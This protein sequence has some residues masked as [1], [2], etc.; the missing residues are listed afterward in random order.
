MSLVMKDINGMKMKKENNNVLM[1]KDIC[2]YLSCNMD[3]RVTIDE[4]ALMFHISAT[5]LK[6]AFKEVSG[7]S[8]YA[9]QRQQKMRAAADDLCRTD[10]TVLQIAGRYGYENGSKFAKAFRD[11]MGMSPSRYRKMSRGTA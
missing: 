4:L 10:D 7:I 1:I 5:Q 8:V 11:T 2:E 9:Y 3:K 6:V